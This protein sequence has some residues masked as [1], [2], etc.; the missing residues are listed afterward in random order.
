MEWVTQETIFYCNGIPLPKPKVNTEPKNANEVA[1]FVFPPVDSIS[2]GPARRAAFNQFIQNPLNDIN[3][4]LKLSVPLYG[5]FQGCVNTFLFRSTISTYSKEQ[6][7]AITL[8][9]IQALKKRRHCED[10]VSKLESNL[11]TLS[12]EYGMTPQEIQIIAAQLTG[13]Q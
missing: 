5:E 12:K 1:E 10:F 4:K 9:I 2:V 7:G 8:S 13:E 6:W 11:E 3:S